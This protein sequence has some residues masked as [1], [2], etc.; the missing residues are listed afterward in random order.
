MKKLFCIISLLACLSLA[1]TVQADLFSGFDSN[2]EGW[3]TEGATAPTHVASGGNPGG[4]IKAYDNAG[5]WWRFVSPNSW[6]GDWSG[7]S[8]GTVQ[9]DLQPLYNNANQY[10]HYVE[11]WS[12]SNYMWWEQNIHPK[13]G[14]WT[15]FAVQLTDANFTEVGGTF[16]E[17]LQNVTAL[18][19]LGD[20]VNGSG[21]Q[22]TTGLDNVRVSALVVPLPGTVWLLGAGLLGLASLRRRR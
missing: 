18:K 22:D 10:S 6:D 9:F 3:T 20:I 12:G 11:I 14:E 15:H 5:T 8:N 17:I 4:Y 2:A 21:T 16:T 7:Y 19:I 13:K 1:G